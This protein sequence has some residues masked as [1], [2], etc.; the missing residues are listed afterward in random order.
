[1]WSRKKDV[2]ESAMSRTKQER[3]RNKEEYSFIA[4]WR[5]NKRKETGDVI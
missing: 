2:V 4:D 3:S 5:T 1:M